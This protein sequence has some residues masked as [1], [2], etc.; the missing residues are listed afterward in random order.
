MCCDGSV[1]DSRRRQNN[2]PELLN[3]ISLWNSKK[4]NSFRA[5]QRNKTRYLID[6]SV[7]LAFYYL[8]CHL[9][10]SY[11][12][13]SLKVSSLGSRFETINCKYKYGL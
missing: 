3:D 11:F 4:G 13:K 12:E 7:I 2:V 8:Y 9:N 5:L 10:S 6:I 1:I